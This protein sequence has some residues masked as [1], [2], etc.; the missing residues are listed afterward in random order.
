MKKQTKTLIK[1]L[2]S[3]SL[4]AWIF[5]TTDWDEF[6]LN[7][8]R[9]NLFYLGLYLV[10]YVLGLV[11][12]SYKWKRI[13]FFRGIKEYSL[14]R[15]FELYLSGTFINNFMPSFIGGDTYKAYQIGKD[16]KEYLKASSTVIVDRI[17]GFMV[18]SGLAV[19]FGSLNYKIVLENRLLSLFYGLIVLAIL[20]GIFVIKFRRWPKFRDFIKS[21]FPKKFLKTFQELYSIN[22]DKRPYR[23]AFFLGTVFN[24]VG[25]G[26]CNYLLF[27]AFGINLSVLDYSSVV[28]LISLIA[29]AP[30]SINNIGVKEWAYIY[31]F[32][33]FGVTASAA[34]SVVIVSRFL[35]M[36]VSLFALP[37][38]LRDRKN[39]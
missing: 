39:L 8:K 33:L 34:L 18:V 5:F 12:S 1:F 21:K 14:M 11:I 22:S 10:F 27:L 24:L 6:F 26:I 17:T 31:F 16:K 2:V 3:F 20:V 37:M 4:L 32:G 36:I 28:F 25:V 30:I 9:M 13:A 15:F 19:F 35:Q 38:Y 7:I 23:E 29:A